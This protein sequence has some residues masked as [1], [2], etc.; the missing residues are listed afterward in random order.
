M[1]TPDI[2]KVIYLIK[3]K[4]DFYDQRLVNDPH[5]HA[6]IECAYEMRTIYGYLTEPD[7]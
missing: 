2:E 1:N 4:I 6:A 5:D 7:F 3:R